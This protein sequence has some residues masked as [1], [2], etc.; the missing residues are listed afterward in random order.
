MANNLDHFDG[1]EPGLER[2]L[3][4]ARPPQVSDLELSKLRSGVRRRLRRE[5]GF[6]S[7]TSASRAGLAG[8]LAASA[9]IAA[10]G[11]AVVGTG[12]PN[13]APGSPEVAE[14]SMELAE[15]G[16][17]RFEFADGE[18]VHRIVKSDRPDSVESGEVL[19][20]RG[21]LHEERNGTPV[22]GTAVFYRVD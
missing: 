18:R 4:Q 11:A 3:E 9:A 1:P 17:V 8:L 6:G 22:P 12:V 5:E 16:A 19:W 15:D 2:L 7:R 13:S 20:A 14:F 21:G 10:L